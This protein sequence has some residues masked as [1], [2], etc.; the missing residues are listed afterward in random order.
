MG[1][2][3]TVPGDRLCAQLRPHLAQDLTCKYVKSVA[4]RKPFHA[5]YHLP[6]LFLLA[7]LG[8]VEHGV[9]PNGQQFS[10]LEELRRYDYAHV[11]GLM[12]AGAV[13]RVRDYGHLAGL[14]RDKQHL[15]VSQLS[16]ERQ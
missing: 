10:P 1:S 14:V 13:G 16:N 11:H 8:R 7:E 4:F 15:L 3:S 9:D 2:C 5:C 12:Y 6:R